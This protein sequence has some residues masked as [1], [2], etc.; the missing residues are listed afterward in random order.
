MSNKILPFLHKVP[1]ADKRTLP[2]KTKPADLTDLSF[3]LSERKGRILVANGFGKMTIINGL[4]SG[5]RGQALLQLVKDHANFTL[6]VVGF[7]GCFEKVA[8]ALEMFY[9]QSIYPFEKV[10]GEIMADLKKGLEVKVLLRRDPNMPFETYTKGIWR[11]GV[12]VTPYIFQL[13][14]KQKAR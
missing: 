11:E 13:K 9:M 8:P 7:G 10:L 1:A 14:I 2:A 3:V 4:R 12:P 6:E 5:K